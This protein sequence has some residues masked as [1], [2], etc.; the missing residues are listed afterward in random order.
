MAILGIETLVYCVEDVKKSS[1]FFEDFGLRLFDRDS[2][3]THFRLPDNSNVI[4]R[5]IRNSP[6]PGSQVEGS[7]V[8][9]VVWGVDTQDNLNRMVAR[10]AADRQVVRDTD[11]TARFI[12]DGGIA[13]AL[14]LWP[15][16]RM[17]R[18]AVDQVNSP[19]NT[20]RMNVHRKWIARAVPKRIM[21]IVYMVPNPEHCLKFVCERLDFRLTDAQRGMGFY[22]RCDGVTDHHSIFFFDS[23]SPMS[24]GTGKLL[25]HHVNYHV[26]DL[27]EIMAGKLYM[28][29]R[30]WAPSV[31]GLGRH[32]ISSA[33][34]FY[35]PCPAGGEAE[36]GA[37]QD[38]LDDNWVPREWDAKFGF[39][40]WV[41]NVPQFWIEGP[42]WDVGFFDRTAPHPGDIQP[43][44]YNLLGNDDS[45]R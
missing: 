2:S 12:A 9:E 16:H 31:W 44:S 8:H 45:A 26:T 10:I 43:R 25:F 7:G 21:H 5:S 39:A 28:E 14:R 1:D 17:P 19:G 23:N 40:Q 13:M 30:G 27:D 22:A 35:L 4:V 34:F 42:S 24:G 36:Y 37:D 6:V 11:G 29:R 18:T 32:R 15:S 3:Q 38:Q 20:N 41:Q 33:L